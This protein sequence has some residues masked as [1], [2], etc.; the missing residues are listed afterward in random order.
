MKK[1]YLDNAATT[2]IHPKVI[3][4]MTK[5]MQEDYGNPSST[6]GFGRQAKSVV[7]LSRKSVAKLL[8]VSA[9]EIIFTSGGT[10]SNNWVLRSAIEALKIERI[11]SR[12]RLVHARAG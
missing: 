9:A 10:E 3:S 8:N 1:A 11:I 12:D 4:E 5:T 2:P 6:H 7:E